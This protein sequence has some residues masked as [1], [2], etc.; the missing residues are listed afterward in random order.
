MAV[1][2][3]RIGLGFVL[4]GAMV[5]GGD[6][7]GGSFEM[8]AGEKGSPES[9][10]GGRDYSI[11]WFVHEGDL[12]TIDVPAAYDVSI[13]WSGFDAT[14]GDGYEYRSHYYK[15]NID[16]VLGVPVIVLPVK[17]IEP[18][19]VPSV[20]VS[21]VSSGVNREMWG[22]VKVHTDLEGEQEAFLN[23]P[24]SSEVENSATRLRGIYGS[25]NRLE[26][27]GGEISGG[28]SPYAT[29]AVGVNAEFEEGDVL[30]GVKP[31]E[32]SLLLVDGIGKTVI[33]GASKLEWV[34]SVSE[35]AKVRS[36]AWG[37]FELGQA[38]EIYGSVKYYLSGFDGFES[39]GDMGAN[40]KLD[41]LVTDVESGEVVYQVDILSY[42][43]ESRF[44][45]W[46]FDLAGDFEAGTYRFDIQM[47]A[48][49][50]SGEVYD[51]DGYVAYSVDLGVRFG[52]DEALLFYEDEVLRFEEELVQY[53]DALVV[54]EVENLLRE[55]LIDRMLLV[56]G[57]EDE[58]VGDGDEFVLDKWEGVIERFMYDDYYEEYG[59]IYSGDGFYG[60]DESEFLAYLEGGSLPSDVALREGELA[61]LSD[62]DLVRLHA[63]GLEIAD[64]NVS[65]AE[66]RD[67]YFAK[68]GVE[69]V[70]T[71][72]EPS[73]VALLVMMGVA[74]LRR[75]G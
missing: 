9:I 46:E 13:D 52:V 5:W 47:Q 48:S 50:K 7:E 54:Y 66:L 11:D 20:G 41:F 51:G 49:A 63:L 33:G 74:M 16:R 26:L 42:G 60:L 73:S 30:L 65:F 43:E 45:A 70:V 44:G 2:F 64:L 71:V 40:E 21:H 59:N 61:E 23:L 19:Y 69:Y 6:V 17:P 14:F 38:G 39:E 10:F 34:H 18:V 58:Y 75:C 22:G 15:K 29:A 67:A 57:L 37:I 31:I 1:V 68:H 53:E 4:A 55:K 8:V 24:D 28:F 56:L 27:V 25:R 72:P 62:E 35:E 12:I 32:Q 36:Q 3:G